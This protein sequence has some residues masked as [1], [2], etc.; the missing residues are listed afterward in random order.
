MQKL[1]KIYQNYKILFLLMLLI[2][3][4]WF[5]IKAGWNKA[6]SDFPNYYVS[7]KLT[8]KGKLNEAYQV[9]QF[10]KHIHSYN[11]NARGLFV[12]YPPTT[13]MVMIALTPYDLLTAKR[14]WILISIAAAIGI[15]IITSKLISIDFI[16]ASILLLI[17]GFNL[18]NDMML[19]QVYLVSLLLLVSALL[20]IKN[21]QFTFAGILWG[22]LSAVKFLPLFY[23]PVL[24]FKKQYKI[25][26]SL[27]LTFVSIHLI[28]LSIAGNE[29]YQSFIDVFI[30]NYLHGKVANV[31]ATSIQ[32][33]SIE[34]LTY[35][36]NQ[37]FALPGW[38]SLIIKILWKTIWLIMA[39]LV[40]YKY[41]SHEA[42][43]KISIASITLLLL[44]FE[45]G[46]ATYHLLFGFIVIISIFEI[47]LPKI[48][49]LSIIVFYG[50]MGFLPYFLHFL[51]LENLLLNFS[52]L[53][54]LSLF[55]ACYFFALKKHQI[56]IK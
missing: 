35:Q 49:K 55:A 52:R 4:F 54:C 23:I 19:G 28:T 37:L 17:S 41:K 25:A 18:Y 30:Q 10:N 48:W 39:F 11:T 51:D 6:N 31:T 56:F 9:N 5:G 7:A 53:W 47:S 34:V 3:L 50:F 22:I 46:S 44:L 42:F 2:P 16:D 45:N 13:G 40:I 36:L 15:I 12:M 27:I 14:L 33:Q 20:L 38:I 21:H 24:C 26:L 8:L 32:Y 29:A 1:I 43:L